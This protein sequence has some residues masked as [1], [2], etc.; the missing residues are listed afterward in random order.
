MLTTILNEIKVREPSTSSM[1]RDTVT[2]REE[3]EW[4]A[5]EQEEDVTCK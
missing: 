5:N 2:Y 3:Q 1:L 4:K